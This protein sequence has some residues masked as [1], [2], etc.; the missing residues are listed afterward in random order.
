MILAIVIYAGY[1]SYEYIYKP[2]FVQNEIMP[3]TLEIKK[4]A[5]Q[6]IVDN[7]TQKQEIIDNIINK[8]YPDP[9]FLIGEEFKLKNPRSED[10][11]EK[12]YESPKGIICDIAPTI[13]ELMQISKPPE[14]TGESLL[15]IIT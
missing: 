1:I 3:F 6:S 7:Y 4:P 13:L 8:N 12:I 11:M 14:M 15:K 5:Y 2:I 10:E 9:F